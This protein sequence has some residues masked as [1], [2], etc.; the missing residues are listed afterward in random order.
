MNWEQHLTAARD[1]AN[2]FAGTVNEAVSG[3]IIGGWQGVAS[4]ALA[5]LV[6]FLLTSLISPR[7]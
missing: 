2:W 4:F 3:Y 7:R 1:Q 6:M 5:I